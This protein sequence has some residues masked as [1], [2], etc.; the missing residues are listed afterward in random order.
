G[1]W[2]W[3][4][5]IKP[6]IVV[7]SCVLF[8]LVAS[9]FQSILPSHCWTLNGEKCSQ[10]CGPRFQGRWEGSGEDFYAKISGK[11]SSSDRNFFI[12]GINTPFG[13][14]ERQT[15][16]I[17]RHFGGRV[18]EL[19]Y[20]PARGIKDGILDTF[21]YIRNQNSP[22]LQHHVNMILEAAAQLGPGGRINIITWSSGG[23]LGKQILR[24]L[25]PEV[26]SMINMDAI[27][28]PVPLEKN[29]ARSVTNH[30]VRN[31]PVTFPWAMQRHA[32]SK[33]DIVRWPSNPSFVGHAFNNLS[34]QL[35]L[36]YIAK[37]RF[38]DWET[39]EAA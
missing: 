2:S 5:I 23:A 17:A 36:A 35:A 28:S 24:R 18:V 7:G 3:K 15:K 6:A 30:Y 9:N 20:N 34:T 11:A 19:L 14:A 26:R 13:E 1:L 21:A 39:E 4:K 16:D 38:P 22:G 33:Y 29:L 37:K 25:P 12:N 8:Y 10:K 31:D 32:H 27:C